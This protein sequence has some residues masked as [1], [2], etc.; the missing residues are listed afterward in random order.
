MNSLTL[1]ETQS[2]VDRHL[3][4]KVHDTCSRKTDHSR[5]L[6]HRE[7]MTL[8]YGISEVTDPLE[9]H[10]CSMILPHCLI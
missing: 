2:G 10:S 4:T 8:P 6:L 3:E 9:N 1:G 5:A 7:N